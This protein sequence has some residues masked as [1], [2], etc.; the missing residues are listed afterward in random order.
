MARVG[1]LLDVTPLRTSRPYRRLYIGTSLAHVGSMF[2]TTA[3]SLQVYDLTSSSLAVGTVGIVGFVPLVVTGLWGGAIVDA[4]DR[5]RVAIWAALAMWLAAFLTLLQALLG[6]THTW[7]LYLLVALNMAA[8]GVESPA[9]Q[10][11]YPRILPARDLPAANALTSMA[12]SLSMLVGPVLAGVLVGAAGY[13]WTYTVN[14]VMTVFVLWGLAGLPPIPPLPPEEAGL[15]AARGPE[16]VGGPDREEGLAAAGHQAGAGGRD[17]EEGLAAAGRQAGVGGPAV[18]AGPAAPRRRGPGLRSVAEG[19][20]YLATRPNIRMTFFTDFCAMILANPLAL[21]PAVAV[22]ALS[23]GPEAVGILTAGTAAG[24][25]AAATFSGRLTGVIY[26]GRYVVGAVAGWGLAVVGF[27]AVVALAQYRMVGPDLAL[28]LGFGAL[29]FAGAFDTVSMVFRNTI[30]QA[31]ADDSMRGRL[32]GIFI[33]VVAGGP[34]LGQFLMGAL[35]AAS[36][37]WVA[38]VVGGVAC[39]V[40]VLALARAQPGFLAYDSRN[41]AP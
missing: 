37:E 22:V 7:V 34:R 26:Q 33:V 40:A 3:L 23:K 13:G 30:M 20:R 36:T 41:P 16:G 24:A 17:R 14:V 18:S 2:T 1:L 5:K 12:M 32:Q 25:L 10:A 6:N 4:F 11:I 8:Y 27:G 28:W 9:R 21:L 29:A 35:A 38:A 39:V 19:F 15:T 31:S